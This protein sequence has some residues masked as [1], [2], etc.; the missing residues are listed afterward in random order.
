MNRMLTWVTT[1]AMAAAVGLGAAQAEEK[2]QEKETDGQTKEP[3]IVSSKIDTEG[4][5]LG[6]LILQALKNGGV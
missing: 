2:Q 1:L 3:V 5:V 6:E 4:A